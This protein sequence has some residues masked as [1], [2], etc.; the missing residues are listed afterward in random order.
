MRYIWAEYLNIDEYLAR[1]VTD[2]LSDDRTNPYIVYST[3][4]G[5]CS[6]LRGVCCVPQR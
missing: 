2:V 5:I 3:R 4:G 1:M 6:V